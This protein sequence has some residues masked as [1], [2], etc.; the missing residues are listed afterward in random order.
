MDAWQVARM[1][2]DGFNAG[3]D[4]IRAIRFYDDKRTEYKVK[5]TTE[6]TKDETNKKGEPTT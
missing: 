5:I 2:R 3:P 1:M 4:G 6:V